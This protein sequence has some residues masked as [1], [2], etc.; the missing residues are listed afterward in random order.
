MKSAQKKTDPGK[1]TGTVTL[2]SVAAHV[3]LTAS[4]VSA[5]LN[6]SSAARSVPA[7]TKQR[8]LTA[9]N[10]LKYRPNFL[11]RSLRANRT[12]TIGVILE[13]IG[14]AY[15]SMVM[16]GVEHYLKQHN[17]FF[18]TVAHRHD[19]TLLD[20]YSTMLRERGVEG[21]ITVDTLL[22]EEP[23]LPTVSVAGHRSLKGVTNIVLDHHRAASLALE[24][25]VELGHEKI[26]FMKGSAV[27]SDTDARWN[28]ICEISKK[29]GI[30]IRPELVV[31]LEGAD[32]TPNL[33]YPFAQ[34][35]LA[36]KQPFTALFAYNDISAIGSI[37]AFQEAGLR[38]PQD[39]SVVGFDD[40]QSAGY[41]NPP[42]TTVRQPLQ[43]MGE[44]AA[45][46]LL[47]RIE[48]RIKYVSE[49]SIEP[50]LVVRKS[51]APPSRVD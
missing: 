15:G 43:R 18:L 24:H 1:K 39:L 7:H 5:V 19:H 46:T 31:Q 22:S 34:R 29:L 12:Y 21:F 42:L 16:S 35:L 41:I 20:T 37:C 17:F 36:R 26:A 23:S 9:A 10:E 33:G 47:E 48:G 14:D 45:R 51:T 8:V 13:E 44:I 49:I 30:R 6:N 4:T 32:S 3:G 25:L 38:V 2:K 27:S 40:I 11:A 28:A 50:E